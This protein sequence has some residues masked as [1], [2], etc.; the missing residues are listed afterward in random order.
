MLGQIEPPLITS[1]SVMTE[2]AWMLRHDTEVVGRMFRGAAEGLFDIGHLTAE[3]LPAIDELRR[4]YADLS[5]QLADLT[6][7][8]LANRENLDTVFTLDQRDF[9][10]FR[11]GRK[12]LRLLPGDE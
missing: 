6:L 4:R 7:L 10:V 1:W 11:A 8:H 5:P 2:A 9:R 3:D 12:S